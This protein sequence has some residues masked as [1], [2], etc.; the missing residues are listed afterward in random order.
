MRV[1]GYLRKV[2]LIS[3]LDHC[4]LNV[5]WGSVVFY[6]QFNSLEQMKLFAVLGAL[7]WVILLAFNSVVAYALARPVQEGLGR[8]ADNTIES[9]ELLA[10]DRRN[11]LLPALMSMAVLV[12]IGVLSGSLYLIATHFGIGQIHAASVLFAFSAGCLAL[13]LVIF[14]TLYFVVPPAQDIICAACL[15][16]GLR[17]RMKGFRLRHKLV[18]TILLITMGMTIWMVMMGFC[19]GLR[20][21]CREAAADTL[22]MQGYAV[23]NIQGQDGSSARMTDIKNAV[24]RI[25]SSGMGPSF[26]ADANGKVIYNPANVEVFNRYWQ[27]INERIRSGLTSNRPGSVYEN[28]HEQLVCFTPV[29]GGMAIGTA[30]SI[31][32]RLPY[33]TVFVAASVALVAAALA[34]IL[35]V[36]FSLVFMVAKPIAS[37]RNSLMN[38][39]TGNGD[40][41]A[42]L[43][44]L[45][46]DECGELALEFNRFVDTL[47]GIIARVKHAVGVVRSASGE[48]TSGSQDLSQ[49]TQEQAAAMEEMASAIEQI[50]S[51]IKL[52]AENAGGGREMMGEM[53]R[54]AKECEATARDLEQGMSAI[55]ES[56]KLIGEIIVTVNAVAFQTNLLALNAAVEAARAGEHGKGFAVVA[57]EVRSLA[58]RSAAA[59]LEIRALVEDTV[60]KILAG[61]RMVKR[62]GDWQRRI[63]DHINA[64]YGTMGQIADASSEQAGSVDEVSRAVVQVDASTQQNASTVQQLTASAE[65]LNIEVETLFEMVKG[66]RV[67]SLK[68]EE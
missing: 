2:L 23:G 54:I 5:G 40:L 22:A 67:S 29:G 31:R 36:G 6:C 9:G 20:L 63:V 55:S 48:M 8:I 18:L 19:E 15:K 7:V 28:V 25:A 50:T 62:S 65:S 41:T 11:R 58:Q 56:S 45:S 4:L 17:Y 3:S 39:N 13:P 53:V 27:D 42:R 30:I 26:L 24:D 1:N 60:E 64:L 49:A 10:I 34:F 44:V 37:V 59:V 35:L 12:Q 57:S 16:R 38:L 61:D 66:F 21:I 14:G 32:D 52:T 43:P 46:D 47:D 51:S 33:F 68:G